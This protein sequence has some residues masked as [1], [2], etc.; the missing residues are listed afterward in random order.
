LN[1]GDSIPNL[2][3]C[4]IIKYGV[5]RFRDD[6]ISMRRGSHECFVHPMRY[7]AHRYC[8]APFVAGRMV[9]D[10][11]VIPSG[12]TQA[13]WQSDVRPEDHPVCVALVDDR[14]G[15]VRAG[16]SVLGHLGVFSSR[17]CIG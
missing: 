13:L 12:R 8:S 1:S 10:S 16:V 9:L 4:S 2:R 3:L 7:S 17:R 6:V 5:P 15:C 14:V 11:A